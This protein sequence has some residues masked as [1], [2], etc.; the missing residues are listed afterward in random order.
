G[1][2]GLLFAAWGSGA[3]SRSLASGPPRM[4][5]V[6]SVR[7]ASLDVRL[8]AR[9]FEFTVAASILA[10][11]AFSVMPAMRGL[12]V[13]LAP[14]LVGRVAIGAGSTGRFGL[15]KALIVGQVALSVLLLTGAGLFARSLWHLRSQNLGV[16]DRHT[17]LVWTSP[18]QSGKVRAALI[19]L[20][21]T[22]RQRLSSLPGV[23]AVAP[24]TQ[25]LLDG[26]I[27]GGSS[28]RMRIE[29][30]EAPPGVKYRS[31]VISPDYFKVVGIPVLR[32]REFSDQ[33]T[34]GSR[35]VVIIT[36]NLAR[37]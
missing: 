8:D 30:R 29:G 25:G 9:V 20:F 21:E 26:G 17:L 35:P 15:G 7:M 11:I 12:R 28:E 27:D 18:E 5:S 16:D 32:G 10:M 23:V 6:M 19:P 13:G 14:V 3:L 22:V 37:L 31:T 2:L 36:E 33:D 24:A 34:E 1:V 4:A